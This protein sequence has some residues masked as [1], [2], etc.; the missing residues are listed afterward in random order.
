[1]DDEY[2]CNKL[3]HLIEL[4][5]GEK[6]KGFAEVSWSKS[7]VFGIRDKYGTESRNVVEKPIALYLVSDNNI[8]YTGKL[9]KIRRKRYRDGYGKKTR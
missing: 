4:L 5:T 3:K 7:F 2:I 8:P 1:M 6:G 9:I